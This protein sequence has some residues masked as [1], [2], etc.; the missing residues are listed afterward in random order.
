MALIKG[1]REMN[2]KISRCCFLLIG[3]VFSFA[4]PLR[5]G[6]A[7]QDLFTVVS[8]KPS[9]LKDDAFYARRFHGA[10][11][12]RAISVADLIHMSYSEL[13]RDAQIV[14]APDWCFSEKYDIQAKPDDFETAKEPAT[15][16]EY[17][18]E[19]QRFQLSLRGL[20]ADRFRFQAHL[21]SRQT[22]I[23]ALVIG[24]HGPKFKEARENRRAMRSS[25]GPQIISEG[26]T[27]KD[28]AANVALETGR[29]V[30]DATGLPDTT[31]FLS[32]GRA[33][34]TIWLPQIRVR[35]ASGKRARQSMP[36]WSSNSALNWNH[37]ESRLTFS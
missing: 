36:P 8:I 11:N 9:N 33:T 5:K 20:L 32:P 1:G 25:P 10:L 24:K 35:N 29:M 19:H 12:A 7:S 30:V 22:K 4:K 3:V 18:A 23:L 6:N 14:N 16:R 37:A 31:K 13:P 17:Q 34:K 27:M 26:M 15:D 28:L 2:M 21:E